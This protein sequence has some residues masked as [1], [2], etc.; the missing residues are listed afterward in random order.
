MLSLLRE[1]PATGSFYAQLAF[2][3][4]RTLHVERAR[5]LVNVG[6]RLEP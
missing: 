4:M 1:Y 6:L 2:L 3:M 5:D